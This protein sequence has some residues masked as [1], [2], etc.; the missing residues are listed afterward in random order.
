N[1]RHKWCAYAPPLY[2]TKLAAFTISTISGS[3][4]LRSNRSQGMSS[5]V[6]EPIMSLRPV[7]CIARSV[8]AI[9]IARNHTQTDIAPPTWPAGAGRLLVKSTRQIEL[10]PSLLDTLIVDIRE[11]KTHLSRLVERAAKGE[12]R[13]K[14]GKG[15]T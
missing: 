15:K 11:A 5:S 14:P 9:P 7:E 2:S 6:Q 12:P 13:A 8:R 4:L 10:D 3:S 1:M